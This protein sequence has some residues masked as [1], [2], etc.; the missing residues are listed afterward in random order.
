MRDTTLTSIPIVEIIV[1]VGFLLLILIKRE[2]YDRYEPR[3]RSI[4]T[5]IVIVV[6]LALPPQST[7]IRMI[8]ERIVSQVS[9]FIS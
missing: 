2:Y 8:F 7:V 9:E 5:I 4:I 1:I 3:F 6:I